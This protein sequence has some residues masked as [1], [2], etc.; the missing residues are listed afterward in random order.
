MAV[1]TRPKKSKAKSQ[2]SPPP[3]YVPD[4]SIPYPDPSLLVTE[5][6][7]PVDNRFTEM[8]QRL[9]VE[10]LYGSWKPSDGR[11]FRAYCNVGLFHAYKEPP[12]CPDAMLVLGVAPSDAITE[13]EQ[14]SYFIWFIGKPPDVVIECVSDTRGGEDTTKLAHYASIGVPYVVVFDPNH[15]LKNGVLRA[16]AL[17]EGSYRAIDPSKLSRVGL[18]FKLWDGLYENEKATWLRWVDADGRLIATTK[19]RAD[20]ETE[21]HHAT[22]QL[23]RDAE[24]KNAE[25]LAR[26]REL[27]SQNGKR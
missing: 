22:K 5:D 24:A 27:E 7:A 2:L 16:F 19:E 4:P 9:L 23:L 21:K 11:P 15:V 12:V 20:T 10:P 26:L 25:L 6:G 3:A 18:G 17:D 14:R 8:Q 13:V 1:L